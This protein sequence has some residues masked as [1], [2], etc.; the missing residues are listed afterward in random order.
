MKGRVYKRGN[1]F[2]YEIDHGKD[3][4]TRKRKR[5]YK[6]GFKTA[7]EAEIAMQEYMVD[8]RR[9]DLIPDTD[10]TL[11]EFSQI[12]LKLYKNTHKVKISTVRIREKQINNLLSYFKEVKLKDVTKVMY[13]D[14]L[15]ELSERLAKNTLSGVNATGKMIFRKA[16]ELD[17]LKDDPTEYALLPRKNEVTIE[18]LENEEHIPLY[19]E[20]EELAEFLSTCEELFSLQTYS[21]FMVLAYTG[22]RAGELCA[23]KW[24]DVDMKNNTIKIYKTYYNPNNNTV[25]YTLLPPKTAA[26]RR[27]IE[28]DED[29]IQLLKQHKAEQNALILKTPSWHKEGFVFTK[30]L[31]YPGYPE[32]VK[33]IEYLMARI[34]KKT[35][36]S[37]HL[38]PHSL[39]HTHISLLAEAGASL[40]EIMD[41]VGHVD[42]DTTRKIYL[43]VTKDMK[44]ETSHKFSTLM[45][46]L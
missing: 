14:M 26:S 44:K 41:R 6:G 1:S 33:Q 24:K 31:N 38:T 17:Y 11:R 32:T 10:I 16:V 27:T 46:S 30:V 34:L 4:I 28:V 7:E 20:K 19:F 23:L 36:I 37:K 2:Y 25:K 39:R 29:V 22:M 5:S 15:F 18:E 3:P 45:K 9:G 43:H 8:F 12:W 13:Q 21:I 35:K 42:D 40:E